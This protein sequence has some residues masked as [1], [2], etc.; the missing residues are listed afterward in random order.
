MLDTKKKKK[1]DI[2]NLELT[3]VVNFVSIKH[4]NIG[5]TTSWKPMF[6]LS[7]LTRRPS[8]TFLLRY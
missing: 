4:V 2:E 8:R 5:V 3:L 1:R 6:P 7:N